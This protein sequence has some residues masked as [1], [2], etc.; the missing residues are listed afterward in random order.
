MHRARI[1]QKFLQD[2]VDPTGVAAAFRVLLGFDRV[3]FFQNLD[4]DRQVVLLEL[5]D[6]VRVVEEDVGV[7]DKGFHLCR[8]LEPR[9]WGDRPAQVFHRV[10]ILLVTLQTPCRL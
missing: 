1:G 10:D 9:F 6:R 3:Q 7:Q 5:V 8:D 2:A 4:G